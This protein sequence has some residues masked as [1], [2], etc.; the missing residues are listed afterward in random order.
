LSFH[1]QQVPFGAGHAHHVAEAGEDDLGPLGDGYALVYA[2]HGQHA[3]GAARPVYQL[4]LVRQEVFDAVA[5]DCVGVTPAD[6]HELVV[7]VRVGD[8]G[9]LRRH[10]PRD[11]GVPE[12]V[13][14]FHVALSGRSG[15]RFYLADSYAAVG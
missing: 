3:D 12:L 5:V 15:I 4:Y 1:L 11:L 14:V 13:Y 6:L 10:R 2:A 9:D 8:R 7:L